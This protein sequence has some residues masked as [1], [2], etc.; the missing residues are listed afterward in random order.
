MNDKNENLKSENKRPGISVKDTILTGM[1]AGLIAVCA[2]ITV[3]AAV[4]F[5]MQTFGMFMA[6]YML[7]G[8]KGSLAVLVYILLGAVGLPVFSG[9]KGGIGVI[10][11]TTGGYIVGFL[12]SALFAW[13][14]ET[15]TGK[16]IK[17]KGKIVKMIFT[18]TEMTMALLI[19]YAFGTA[20]FMYVYSSTKEPVGLLLCLSWCV[21]PFIIPDVIKMAAA[22]LLGANLKRFLKA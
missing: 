8:K 11:G 4:P 13:G 20:W 15:V 22:I 6:I 5:T 19:C 18:I 3:P 10:L 2:W 9:F 12:I 14:F 16:L 21:F 17:E 7:G 1:F